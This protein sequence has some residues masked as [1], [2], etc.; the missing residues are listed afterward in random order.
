MQSS[1][2]TKDNQKQCFTLERREAA[3]LLQLLIILFDLLGFYYG[4]AR[5]PNAQC[6]LY[7]PQ[8]T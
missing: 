3:L 8:Q 6:R 5:V 7:V 4:K 2:L 1:L